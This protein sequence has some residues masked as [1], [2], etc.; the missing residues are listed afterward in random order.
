MPSKHPY[1]SKQRAQIERLNA[2]MEGTLSHN[3]ALQRK[4]YPCAARIA[5]YLSLVTT[6]PWL[7]TNWLSIARRY[8][9]TAR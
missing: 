8:S 9:E 1:A 4:D 5:S 2:Y 7:A 3:D 6:N